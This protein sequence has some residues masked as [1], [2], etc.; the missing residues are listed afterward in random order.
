MFWG[1][2]PFKETPILVYDKCLPAFFLNNLIPPTNPKVTSPQFL[3]VLCS[4]FF[5]N[6]TQRSC[7]R[8]L[9]TKT[10]SFRF[11]GVFH[12][13]TMM[14]NIPGPIE[15]LGV[16][17]IT[18]SLGDPRDL[19]S[20]LRLQIPKQNLVG[21]FSPTH[22]KKYARSSYWIISPGIRVKSKKLG[23]HH[24]AIDLSH[25][26]KAKAKSFYGFPAFL[27]GG[28]SCELFLGIPNLCLVYWMTYQPCFWVF[29]NLSIGSSPYPPRP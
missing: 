5:P 22:L 12:V 21:G 29:V 1:V 28:F 6:F 27:Q 23:K 17:R 20:K 11:G 19:D 16:A 15:H 18:E 13:G 4:S 10:G 26:E 3:Q 14:V 8:A 9:L 24:L 25:Q 2:P 7:F